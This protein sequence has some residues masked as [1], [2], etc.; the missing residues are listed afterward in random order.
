MGKE[1]NIFSMR[2]WNAT[3]LYTSVKI[4]NSNAVIN[5]Y[6]EPACRTIEGDASNTRS[7]E[8]VPIK[9]LVRLRTAR[10]RHDACDDYKRY[11]ISENP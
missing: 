4:Q 9:N 10:N 1:Q 5:S 2:E 8:L 3:N 11:G 6:V 7:M